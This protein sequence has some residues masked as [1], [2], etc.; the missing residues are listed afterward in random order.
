MPVW[1]EHG[2]NMDLRSFKALS[3]GDLPSDEIHPIGVSELNRYIA[4]LFTGNAYLSDLCVRGELSNFVAHPSGH[5]YFSLKDEESLIRAVM[6]R[7]AASRLRFRPENGMKVLVYGSVSVYPKEGRYQ[8]YVNRLVP[9]G[10]G[11][12]YLSYEQI[13]EKLQA[14]GLFDPARKKPLPRY[15][16]CIGVITSPSGAA[17]R[18]IIHITGRRFPLAK[19]C[20]YPALVQGKEAPPTLIAGL[21]YF[22]THR[23][24]DLIILGRGGGSAEDLFAFNDEALVR[25][26]AMSAVPVISAVGHETDVTLCDFAADR[27]APTPSAAAELSVPSRA[28]LLSHLSDMGTRM[29]GLLKGLLRQ[30][31]R[32]LILL[33]GRPVMKNPALLLNGRRMHA[34]TLSDCLVRNMKGILERRGAQI[35]KSAARLEALSPLSVLGRGYAVVDGAGGRVITSVREV[36][37]GDRLR[38]RL[39]D[40]SVTGYAEKVTPEAWPRESED[41]NCPEKNERETE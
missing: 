11:E 26:V 21:R 18:D 31:R 19:I 24:A 22:N 2:G 9:E 25:E 30:R 34:A 37:P 4:G 14:E 5:C 23:I 32:N 39:R 16:S 38:I 12:L 17:V 1:S 3:G 8:I 15:P 13:R 40:G 35:A 41:R 10:I 7:S 27:R 36:M 6:F 28:E 29:G 33:S 20:I